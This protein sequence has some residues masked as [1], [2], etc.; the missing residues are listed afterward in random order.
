MLFV[1][2]MAIPELKGSSV[3]SFPYGTEKKPREGE[4]RYRHTA[5]AAEEA[6]C[7]LDRKGSMQF[8]NHYMA[9]LLGYGDADLVGRDWLDFVFPQDSEQARARLE[10]NWRGRSER[11]DFRFRHKDGSDVW[12]VACTCP[13]SSKVEDITGVIGIF[14]DAAEQNKAQQALRE[15]E[16][17]LQLA[18]AA[19]QLHIWT[20]D[21][22]SQI[23]FASPGAAKIFGLSDDQPI[24]YSAWIDR[25]YAP[26]RKYVLRARD[27]LTGGKA[28]YDVQFRVRLPNGELRWVDS[29]AIVVHD[30]RSRPFQ[31][32]GV[33]A[34]ITEKKRAERELHQRQQEFKT[35]VENA[36]DIISRL[37]RDLRHL[38]VNP[39]VESAWGVNVGDYLG[40]SKA[41]LGLPENMVKPWEQAARAAF[42]TGQEQR[43]NFS[44]SKDGKTHYYSARMLPEFDRDGKVESVLGI[45]YDETER[46]EIELERDGLLMREQTARRQAEAATRARDEFLAVVSHELRSPLNGIQSWAH[47]L[48]SQLPQQSSPAII[49]RALQG[50]RTG[51]SQQVHLIEDLLDVTGMMSGKL[52]LVK[53][54]LPVLPAVQAAVDSVGPLAATKRIEIQTRYDINAEQVEGDSD[55]IQQ[56]I[57]NLLSNAVKFTPFGGHVWVSA[58]TR[59][60]MVYVMVRDDGVGISADFLPELF[61][62]F[63]QADASSTRAHGGL[64]LGLS[65]ARHLVELHGGRISAESEGEG[66]GAT[67]TVSFPLVDGLSSDNNQTPEAS[68]L[69]LPSLRNMKILLVD[70]HEEA[71]ESLTTLL[72]QNG[73]QVIAAASG[74]EALRSLDE[75]HAAEMPHILLCDIA[76]PDEDGYAV[77]RRVRAWE[78]KHTGVSLQQLPAV[79]LTAFAQND[80]RLRAL[81]AGFQM[82]LAK[83]VAPQELIAVIAGLTRRT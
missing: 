52:H 39:A 11:F 22:S 45:T 12:V 47:V 67:F 68:L 78:S 18:L 46:T 59:N 49:Q 5:H 55:R 42:A 69:V 3:S 30:R 80:D 21:L 51:V 35:L 19:A 44:F 26:D 37:D 34:D 20:I 17:R 70:D 82:Y 14:T 56:I 58:Y 65:M 72:R 74:G 75:L 73:A 33:V 83:P 28:R 77:L 13:N 38:Y 63:Q 57:S 76:M 15:W 10:S 61:H 41:E 64:G 27:A 40:R 9:Q 79:A 60:D 50:I 4:R 16:Q 6:V 23:V 66:K 25:V 48:E 53:R 43:F 32:Y 2:D 24:P 7:F 62:R 8:A 36:P 1:A 31:I 71:R 81:S 54:P 29:Q